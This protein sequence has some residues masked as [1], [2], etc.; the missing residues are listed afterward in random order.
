MSD[1]KHD[2]MDRVLLKL[3][4]TYEKDEVVSALYKKLSERD[5][6]IGELVSERDEAIYERDQLQ[7]ELNRIKHGLQ[8]SKEFTKEVKREELY[9]NLRKQISKLKAELKT[10]RNDRDNLYSKLF[11]KKD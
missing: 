8:T 4:R 6:K 9:G 2:F 7:K 5:F 11:N 1:K 3:K 10:M